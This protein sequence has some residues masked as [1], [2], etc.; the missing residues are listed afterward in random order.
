MAV[1]PT[2]SPRPTGFALLDWWR[3]RTSFL[4]DSRHYAVNDAFNAWWT[5]PG[6][7]RAVILYVPEAISEASALFWL[8]GSL[9]LVV[10]LLVRA[11]P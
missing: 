9:A 7:G 11:R 6:D 3:L 10:T 8:V 1:I 5:P 4:P 2:S